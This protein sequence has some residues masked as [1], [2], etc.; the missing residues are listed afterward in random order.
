MVPTSKRKRKRASSTISRARTSTEDN[1][2]RRKR[3]RPGADGEN[4]RPSRSQ[5]QEASPG[6]SNVSSQSQ[7]VEITEDMSQEELYRASRQLQARCNEFERH[8][9][10][11]N[12]D[13]LAD[14]TNTQGDDSDSDSDVDKKELS[15]IRSL[16][17]KFAVT[18][19]LWLPGDKQLFEAELDDTFNPLERFGLD[20]EVDQPFNREQGAL[21]AVYA[22]IP[23]EY[24][25][26]TEF[27]GWV[28]T[29]FLAGMKAERQAVR[30]RLRA[31]PDLFGRTIDQFATP[32]SREE[33][34]ELI[35]RC[36]DPQ[37]PGKFYY[38]TFDVPLLHEDNADKLNIDTFLLNPM[39]FTVH[40]A[41]TKGLTG[42]SE[43]VTGVDPPK[44]G[45]N[46]QLWRL[47][48]TT[49]GM[50]AGAAVW[51]RWIH[52]RDHF[53]A[54][55]G[56]ITGIKWDLEHE[57]YLRWLQ[58][59]IDNKVDCVLDIFRRWDEKFYPRAAT[60]GGDESNTDAVEA[61]Q[62]AAMEALK[63]RVDEAQ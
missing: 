9:L 2:R 59:G 26:D 43:T 40:A 53:F 36:P 33:F 3:A 4:E 39:L 54:E 12:R 37:N 19:M 35:G 21:R 46:Q 5:S 63:Q 17:K 15:F 10:E 55:T 18:D 41:I 52:S 14:V 48:K 8:Q 25:D 56:A 44:L 32:E 50:I 62:V 30:N 42:G 47:N 20:S 23:K 45:T 34:A 24:H 1:P 13:A 6:P 58:L 60:E 57:A 7:G 22:A 51:L 49:P 38:N 11:A 27:T 31:H 28:R 61:S 29:Q 16:G